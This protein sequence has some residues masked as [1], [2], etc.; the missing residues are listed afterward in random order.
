MKKRSQP[1][2][3]KMP[4]KLFQN[5]KTV[6]TVYFVLRVLVILAMVHQLLLKNYENVFLCSLTLLVSQFLLQR[7][8]D[9]VFLWS[10]ESAFRFLSAAFH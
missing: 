8:I 6:M 5:K 10:V 2:R 7:S 4:W 1:W 3:E 9:K